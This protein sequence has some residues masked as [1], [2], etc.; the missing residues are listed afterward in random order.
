MLKNK[1]APR[2]SLRLSFMLHAAHRL[3][4]GHPCLKMQ[5]LEL[6]YFRYTHTVF[7]FRCNIRN[8]LLSVGGGKKKL[9]VHWVAMK[10]AMKHT[11]VNRF[12]PSTYATQ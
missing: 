6:P 1:G 12:Y 11:P 9:K 7:V 2:C 5:P 10:P 8:I 4:F 3:H